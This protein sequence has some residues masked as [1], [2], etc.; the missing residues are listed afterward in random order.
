MVNY[1]LHM[2]VKLLIKKCKAQ[3]NLTL[4]LHQLCITT[5]FYQSYRMLGN[6]NSHAHMLLSPVV[7]LPKPAPQPKLNLW[8][9]NERENPRWDLRGWSLGCLAARNEGK[10][11]L[12]V[13]I[14]QRCDIKP[15]R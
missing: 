8:D 9:F 4:N 15:S 13:I 11:M 5:V 3:D 7:P 1:I 6:V 10:S 2:C 14:S 12:G